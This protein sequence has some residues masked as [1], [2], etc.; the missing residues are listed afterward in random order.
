MHAAADAAPLRIKWHASLVNMEVVML[1]NFF[2]DSAR[3]FAI[4]E[5]PA[6]PLLEG[7]AGYLFRSGYSK[8]SARRHIRSAEHIVHWAIRTI[9]GTRC[10]VLPHRSEPAGGSRQSD[11]K[12][13]RL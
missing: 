1:S 13:S 9:A 11:R 2:N 12:R 8:I 4:H 3:M 7:F 6:G 10:V 5:G